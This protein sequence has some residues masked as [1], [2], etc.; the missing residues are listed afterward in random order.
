[1]R[2]HS[3]PENDQSRAHQHDK[4][5]QAVGFTPPPHRQVSEPEPLGGNESSPAPFAASIQ[6]KQAVPS[7]VPLPVIQGVFQRGN[8]DDTQRGQSGELREML[9]TAHNAN[10]QFVGKLTTYN[11]T[12]DNTVELRKGKKRNVT[13]RS[14][15]NIDYTFSVYFED[16]HDAVVE[17]SAAGYVHEGRNLKYSRTDEN[18][19]R[20]IGDPVEGQMLGM[21]ASRRV[22]SQADVPVDYFESHLS[23]KHG[24][25]YFKQKTPDRMNTKTPSFRDLVDSGRDLRMVKQDHNV[26]QQERDSANSVMGAS[27]T[28]YAGHLGRIREDQDERVTGNI[29]NGISYEWCHLI[30]HGDGGVEIPENFVSGSHYAN[31]EQLAIETGLRKFRDCGLELQVWAFFPAIREDINVD[32]YFAD[33]VV[34]DI[35]YQGQEIFSHTF[36]LHSPS[37]DVREWNMLQADVQNKLGELFYDKINREQQKELN[38]S[39]DEMIGDG[40]DQVNDRLGRTTKNFERELWGQLSSSAEEMAFNL[41]VTGKLL[42]WQAQQ[43]L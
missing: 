17:L 32:A 37:F 21:S 42:A 7:A 29:R 3:S 36:S 33:Y 43:M 13:Y 11:K 23:G 30:G 18:E 1:M 27:A 31:T 19:Y 28:Q 40:T 22:E 24:I 4:R 41:K 39:L 14:A 15:T 2:S 6:R 35:L 10:D 12:A 16:G 38:A 8:L 34:Y 25:R 9:L 5:A 20:W 26:P